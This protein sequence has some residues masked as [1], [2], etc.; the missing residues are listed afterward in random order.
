VILAVM[1]QC[2]EV[3]YVL[4]L[5]ETSLSSCIFLFQSTHT[6]IRNPLL[7]QSLL[8]DPYLLKPARPAVE[9]KQPEPDPYNV[10]SILSRNQS[11]VGNYLIKISTVQHHPV[12]LVF[13]EK[14]QLI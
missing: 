7:A 4:Q 9:W 10:F 14:L 12:F 8:S 3:I 1:K 6:S 5:T 11:I 2:E 13:T